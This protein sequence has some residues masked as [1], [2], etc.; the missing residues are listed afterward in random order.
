MD[1]YVVLRS[2]DSLEFYPSNNASIFRVQLQNQI[3]LRGQWY[4]GLVEF[5][6]KFRDSPKDSDDIYVTTNVCDNTVVGGY[7]TRFLR[8]VTL[9]AGTDNVV[10]SS[11]MYVPVSTKNFHF[12]EINLRTY[13][14]EL[15]DLQE[16]RTTVVLHFKKFPFLP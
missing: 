4:V 1:F 8:R 11:P 10:F 3:S 6:I 15:K 16:D 12:I 9:T 5:G 2:S 14:N 13:N 7:A